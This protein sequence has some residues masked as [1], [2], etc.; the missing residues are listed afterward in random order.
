[1]NAYILWFCEI[2]VEG[3]GEVAILVVGLYGWFLVCQCVFCRKVV[4]Y[5]YIG[6]KD[7]GLKQQYVSW[8]EDFRFSECRL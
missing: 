5:Q 1:M 4:K 2:E 3:E 7:G 6:S 8:M